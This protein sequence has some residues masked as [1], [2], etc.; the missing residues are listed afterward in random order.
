MLRA[1][2]TAYVEVNGWKIKVGKI[3]DDEHES[4]CDM[5]S[6]NEILVT[7]TEYLAMKQNFEVAPEKYFGQMK[8]AEFINSIAT[9]HVDEKWIE[10]LASMGYKV[11]EKLSYMTKS[12]N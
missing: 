7:N 12:K 1:I 5:F 6:G 4:V 2:G 3:L 8:V 11:R 10:E 9:G